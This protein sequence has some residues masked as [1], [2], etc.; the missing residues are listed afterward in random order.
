MPEMQPRCEDRPTAE[1]IVIMVVRGLRAAF[2]VTVEEVDARPAPRPPE[3]LNRDL[4]RALR[5][6]AG[7][8]EDGARALAYLRDPGDL[9]FFRERKAGAA[10]LLLGDPAALELR[11]SLEPWEIEVALRA[12]T[13]EKVREYLEGIRSAGRP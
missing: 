7:T 6:L 8:S 12:A 9:P 1:G 11:P 2:L 10:L 3:A 13:D 4:R 5:E